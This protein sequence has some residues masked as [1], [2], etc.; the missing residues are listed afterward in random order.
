MVRAGVHREYRMITEVARGRP[1][2]EVADRVGCHLRMAY[3]W[4][5]RFDASGFTTFQ[6]VPNPK[7]R[8]PVL[9]GA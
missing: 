7:T 4:I 2:A 1:E 5:H 9:T 8:P 3:E 6:Q